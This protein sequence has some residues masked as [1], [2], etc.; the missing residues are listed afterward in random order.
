MKKKEEYIGINTEIREST[1][2]RLK[3]FIR[4]HKTKNTSFNQGFI[5]DISLVYLFDAVMNDNVNFENLASDHIR[6]DA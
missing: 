3:E 6:G 4:N 2:K 5:I 1:H